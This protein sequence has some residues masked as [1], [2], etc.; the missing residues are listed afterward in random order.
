[1][2]PRR[3]ALAPC[4]LAPACTSPRTHASST[5]LRLNN[6]LSPECEN[7]RSVG[8][9]EALPPREG[10]LG[11]GRHR[12]ARSALHTLMRYCVCICIQRGGGVSCWVHANLTRTDG[13]G[14]SPWV[15]QQQRQAALAAPCA[16]SR[17]VPVSRRAPRWSPRAPPPSSRWP[18]SVLRAAAP[19]STAAWTRRLRTTGGAGFGDVHAHI[20]FFTLCSCAL[21]PW[22]RCT[23]SSGSQLVNSLP[24]LALAF[25]PSHADVVTCR[26]ARVAAHLDPTL[27]LPGAAGCAALGAAGPRPVVR[28]GCPHPPTAPRTR[29]SASPLLP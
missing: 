26:F 24:A 15:T 1:V 27:Q 23:P 16:F 10:H 29:T 14:S 3:C 8:D 5:L 28:D 19:T 9:V 12:G 2:P 7:Y 21:P 20:R 6:L 13:L 17:P 11:A 4:P 22:A 18:A 25:V